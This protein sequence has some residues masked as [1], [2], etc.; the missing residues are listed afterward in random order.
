MEQRQA[1]STSAATDQVIPPPTDTVK[2]SD[3]D[4]LG[5]WVV[6]EGTPVILVHGALSWSLLKPLAEELATKGYQAIWYHRRGYKGKPIEPPVEFADQARDA[7]K[8]LDALGIERA[9][10][11]GHSAGAAYALEF[12]LQAEDRLL[13]ATLLDFVLMGQVES[14]Q[15]LTQALMPAMEKAQAGDFRGAAEDMFHGLGATEELL[16]RAAPGSWSAMADDAPTWF[17]IEVPASMR[18]K[19]EPTEV[20]ANKTPIAFLLASDVPP[21]RE[22]AELL[23]EWRPDLRVLELSTTHHFFPLTATQETATVID[24]WIQSLGTPTRVQHHGGCMAE[25]GR[26]LPHWRSHLLRPPDPAEE[27]SRQADLYS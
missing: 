26:A 14:G 22:T 18:W 2:V 15:M 10:V 25:R 20:K 19:A 7:V 4:N 8:V 16:E 27:E 9:H 11:V 3:K 24:G 12:A 21:F 5:V 1:G 13:S 17:Q 23:Q 6:G